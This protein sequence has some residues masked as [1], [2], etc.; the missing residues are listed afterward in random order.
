MIRLTVLYNLPPGSDEEAF[1]QWRM[2]DHQTANSSMPGVMR[3]DFARIDGRFP[4][5]LPLPY[6][7]MTTADWPDRASFEAAFYD[8][9]A[10]AELEENLKKIADPLFMISEI[11]TETK[12]V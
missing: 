2:T 9:Q 8:P 4:S 5:E 7:F 10:L 3:T 11:L 6:R 12:N 1:L